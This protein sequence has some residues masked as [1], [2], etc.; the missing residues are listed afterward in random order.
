MRSRGCS[1]TSLCGPPELYQSS[2]PDIL[3]AAVGQHTRSSAAGSI[4]F[5]FASMSEY[6]QPIS[7]PKSMNDVERRLVLR[8]VVVG[9]PAPRRAPGTNPARVGDDRRRR[10][11]VHQR[12]LEDGGEGPPDD[13]H[14]PGERPRQ[15]R[16]GL[17]RA[18]AE[19]LAWLGQPHAVHSAGGLG[20]E[21]CPRVGVVEPGLCD[22]QP[23]AAFRDAEERRVIPTRGRGCGCAGHDLDE[24][25]LIGRRVL[26]GR[27]PRQQP[28]GR[29]RGHR[30]AGRLTLHRQRGGVLSRKPVPECR[31]IVGDAGDEVH[32]GASGVHE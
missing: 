5:Q 21:S 26:P 32:G 13:E 31:A 15:R 19:A 29:S 9:P 20:V 2:M 22:E 12:R 6:S 10:E 11:V 1:V 24:E 8:A 28:S 7:A 17:H 18:D 4:R 30:K 23:P 27:H 3:L 16:R 14:A 25:I